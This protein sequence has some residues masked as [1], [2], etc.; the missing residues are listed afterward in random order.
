MVIGERVNATLIPAQCS[1]STGIYNCFEDY[2]HTNE[3]GYPA[4]HLVGTDSIAG[5]FVG[6]TYY[7]KVRALDLL[8]REGSFSSAVSGIPYDS[9]IPSVPRDVTVVPCGDSLQIKWF[10]VTRDV[11]G[12]NDSIQNY[13]I[14]RGDSA[15][16]P[17]P[18]NIGT[19]GQVSSDS[20]YVYFMYS[21]NDLRPAFGE[22]IFWYRIKAADV[23]GNFG[24]LSSPVAGYM[25]DTN[26]P[27]PPVNLTAESFEEYIK[28]TWDENAEPDM[29]GYNVYR[30]IC[31]WDSVC[32]EGIEQRGCNKWDY[33]PYPMYLIG[34]IDDKDSTVYEDR[35]VP[36]N[37]PICYRYSVKAFD[38]TQ[39][40][41]DTSKTVCQRLR[42]KTPPNPPV[43][44]GLKARDGAIKV[45]WVSPPVQDLFGF[46]VER[47]DT[48]TGP[49]VR[50]SDELK[51]PEV[52]ECED[53]PVTNAWAADSIFS[54]LDT[55]VVAQKIYYYRVKGADCGGNIGEAS[56][57]VE[58][59]TFDFSAPPKPTDVT[60]SPLS[61]ECALKIEWKPDFDTANHGFVV[62]RSL[63]SNKDYL[64]MSPV[65]EGNEFMDR[66]ITA[67]KQYYYRVQYFGKDGGSSSLSNPV[68]GMVAP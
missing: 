54:F 43:I 1:T 50:I 48:Q 61:G 15:G 64:Q 42:E 41:S 65:I 44:S 51:F 12:R 37:S 11:I 4:W 55:T 22:K 46:I 3:N 20:S 47:A 31:G 53:I 30:G 62:F 9:T 13:T 27:A 19:T 8:G 23:Y 6:Q 29:G 38:M 5:P 28:L 24:N 39:N 63:S 18:I 56:A 14:Y 59:Y 2:L 45:E 16:D 26:P 40:A 32:I 35:G 67:G 7:Y 49:W 66:K 52:V 34:N 21:A 57:Y 10:K 60:V 17:S 36:V 58:T 33:V 68:S 25:S